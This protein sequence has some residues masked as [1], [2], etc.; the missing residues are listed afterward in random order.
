MTWSLVALD[1]L[2]SGC[3]DATPRSGSQ[4]GREG[5]MQDSIIAQGNDYLEHG[6]PKLDFNK[7]A[8]MTQQ[9]PAAPGARP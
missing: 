6:L 4:L 1:S 2:Y 8:R 5:P 3:G 7:S 9:W